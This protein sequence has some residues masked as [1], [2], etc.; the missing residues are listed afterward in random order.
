MKNLKNLSIF[1]F[2]FILH[3]KA[4]DYQYGKIGFPSNAEL[5]NSSD[6]VFV[7]EYTRQDGTVVRAHYRSKAGHGNPDKPVMQ[8][9]KEYKSTLEKEI[10]DYMD[11]DVQKRYGV[12][13]G[14]AADVEREMFIGMPYYSGM[15]NVSI[16]NANGEYRAKRNSLSQEWSQK[17][18]NMKTNLKS[19]RDHL[20]NE[21]LYN[22]VTSPAMFELQ[23]NATEHPNMVE[24]LKRIMPDAV[25]TYIG[26]LT[27]GKNY[28]EENL[29][30]T[31]RMAKTV[32]LRKVS[33]IKDKSLENF[34]SK[35]YS[36]VSKDDVVVVFNSDSKV[37]LSLKNTPKICNIIKNNLAAIKNGQ[38]KNKFLGVNFSD[39]GSSFEKLISANMIAAY[40]K[41]SLY[42]PHFDEKQNLIMYAIDYVDYE[43]N[44]PQNPLNA[45]NN[46]AYELQNSGVVSPYFKIIKLKYT[47]AEYMHILNK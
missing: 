17:Y 15:H 21:D 26:N 6:V 18:M 43:K 41:L 5:A 1:G 47:P 23:K 11:R 19:K 35:T 30:N 42:N 14:F 46:N 7:N 3:Q 44:N 2:F 25:D 32:S 33:D 37:S 36:R 34:I 45:I 29:E 22:F 38:Y 9:P 16:S 4:L 31:K 28:E 24:N 8:S 20:W 40:N 10:N 39:V 13:T 12:P 27:K